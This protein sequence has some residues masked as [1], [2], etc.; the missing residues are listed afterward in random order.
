MISDEGRVSV[1]WQTIFAFLVFFNFIYA[2]I[3]IAYPHIRE[4][5]ADS[6]NFLES[7]IELCWALHILFSFLLASQSLK[8]Y[9]YRDAARRYLT[10]LGVLDIYA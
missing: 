8:I 2:P 3:T 6:V 1:I 10:G 7:T 5:E 9:S 4:T